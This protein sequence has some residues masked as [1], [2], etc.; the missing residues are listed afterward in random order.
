MINDMT[1]I[2]VI[3]FEIFG[4][5]QVCWKCS[6]ITVRCVGLFVSGALDRD[7]TVVKRVIIPRFK[8]F[9]QDVRNIKL[10]RM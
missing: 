7:W 1:S 2:P 4:S 8:A 5:V 3:V 10:K 9:A 6:C